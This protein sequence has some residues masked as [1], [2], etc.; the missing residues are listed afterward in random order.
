MMQLAMITIDREYGGTGE[1][2][3]FLMTHDSIAFYL[4]EDSWQEWIPRLQAVLDNLP[5]KRLFGWGHQL[6][7]TT[8]AEVSV[9]DAQG[10]LSMASLR[11]I[12]K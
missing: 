1:V 6:Q 12:K 4:P 3:M 2:E 10:V 7:F 11:K 5:L 8:D 9:P